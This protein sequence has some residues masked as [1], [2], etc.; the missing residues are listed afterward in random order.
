MALQGGETGADHGQDGAFDGVET[1]L[2]AEAIFD[3]AVSGVDAPG[4][5]GGTDHDGDGVDLGSGEVGGS[6]AGDSGSVVESLDAGQSDNALKK[7]GDV[8]NPG[9]WEQKFKTLEQQVHDNKAWATRVAQENAEL[10]KQ[11]SGKPEGDAP[12]GKTDKDDVL[13][14]D[15]REYYATDPMLQKAVAFEADRLVKQRFGDFDPRSI[16]Q[17]ISVVN[18][19]I[20]QANFERAVMVG[21]VTPKG[22]V[23]GHPDAIAVMSTLD[24]QT[25]FEAEAQRDPAIRSVSDAV[26]AIGIMDR[27]KASVAE[28][29]AQNSQ[30]AQHGAKKQMA[31]MM[32]GAVD[33]GNKAASERVKD[34]KNLSPEE[35]F[36]EGIK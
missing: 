35:A 27:Y 14:D 22:F 33:K 26:A 10:K 9:D 12:E 17:R 29:A 34:D 6:D 7:E 18:E 11:L 13:P 3:A 24:Y 20:E 21:V 32:S 30:A 28:K 4:S 1:E 5:S 36:D 31:D 16:D 2:D 8:F 15:L 19:S 23:K 25:W